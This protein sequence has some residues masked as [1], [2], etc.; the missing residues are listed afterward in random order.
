MLRSAARAPAEEAARAG[1]EAA[2]AILAQGG[3]E[4]LAALAAGAA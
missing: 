1:L 3:G 2:E 4:I